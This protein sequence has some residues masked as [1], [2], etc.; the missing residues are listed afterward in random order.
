MAK[1]T[2]SLDVGGTEIKAA[3]VENGTLLTEIMH[4]PAQSDAFA[5]VILDNF[6]KIINEVRG[7]HELDRICF[8]F[9]GPFDYENG[10][11]L[12]K[13]LAKYDS[14]YGFNLKRYFSDRFDVPREN[15]TFIN[16]VAG[17]A[18]GET[19]FGKAAGAERAMF[20]CIGTGCGSAF[21][22]KNKLCGEEVHGVPPHGYV[23]PTPFLDGCIDDYISKRGIIS[24]SKEIVGLELD[25]KELE[26]M[27]ALGNEKAARAYAVFG[28]RLKNAIEPFV[29]EFAPS[30]LCIG[31]QI[32]RSGDRFLTPLRELCGEMKFE[33]Y[34]TSD[35]SKSAI[36]G[37]SV[38]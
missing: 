5:S 15:V 20:I 18:L 32:T 26:K 8:A 13:G 12:I 31:G 25:G 7:E 24:L 17:F 33:L 22:Y 30:V 6:A 38:K 28:E 2:V 35:T 1:I 9:P 16:D 21:T 14:I 27:A 3:A 29:R 19:N 36:L 34:V 11:C 4:F 37:A 23:Y 10:I